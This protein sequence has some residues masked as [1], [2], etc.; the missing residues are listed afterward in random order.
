MRCIF[1]KTYGGP[2]SA[3]IPRDF[4]CERLHSGVANRG[5]ME[6]WGMAFGKH[7]SSCVYFKAD[8]L[9]MWTHTGVLT[10]IVAMN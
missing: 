1:C 10:L 3:S 4:G 9:N 2:L 7:D 8:N 6:H 5:W